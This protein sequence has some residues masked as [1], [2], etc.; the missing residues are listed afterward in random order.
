[1][2]AWRGGRLGGGLRFVDMQDF[3]GLSLGDVVVHAYD[4]FFFFIHGHLI[5]GS[6][7]RRFRA[8]GSSFRWRRPCRPWSQCADV[9][10]GALLDF[11]GEGF[12]EI[13]AAERI[14]RVGDAGFV[15]MICWVRRARVAANSVGGPGFVEGIGVQRLRAAKNAGEGLD[16]GA[17]DVVS[18]AAAR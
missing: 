17:D 3:Q 16:G 1:L 4:D 9:V 18:W 2:R 6:W 7:L 11:V 12:D 14:N 15:A 10:P 13:G 5:A 8:A